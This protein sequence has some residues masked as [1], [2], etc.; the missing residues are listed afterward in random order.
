[1]PSRCRKGVTKKD[2][3]NRIKAYNH[4]VQQENESIRMQTVARIF[5]HGNRHCNSMLHAQTY[6]DTCRFDQN[7]HIQIRMMSHWSSF[8]TKDQVPQASQSAIMFL[9]RRLIFLLLCFY[10]M[11]FLEREVKH[12][13]QKQIE[14]SLFCS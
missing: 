9:S 12:V 8:T 4:T 6:I 5:D 1:M 2:T 7:K 13:Q 3:H 10:Q 11:L 14:C